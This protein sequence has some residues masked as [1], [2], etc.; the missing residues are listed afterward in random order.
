[1]TPRRSITFVLAALAATTQA[2][3]MQQSEDADVA[4]EVEQF[5]V[6]NA[7]RPGAITAMRVVLTS[8]LD[9]PTPVWVQWEVPNAEGDIAEYGRSVVLNPGSREMVWLYAPLSPHTTDQTRW[10]IRVFEERDG[11]RRRELGG[12]PR[13]SPARSGATRIEL[14]T[15]MIAVVGRARMRLEDYA[16]TWNGRPRPPGAHESTRVISGIA[17]QAL[18]DR[19]EGLSAFEAVIWSDALS[20]LLRNDTA[21]ALRQYIRRGGH[22]II[23]L[24]E[25]GV[26]WELGSVADNLLEDLLVGLKPR[27][28][29]GVMLSELMPLLSKSRHPPV[30]DFEMS[31]RVFKDIGGR[32]DAIDNRYEPLVAM[33]DGRVIAVQRLVDFG[34]ITI[35]GIDLTSQR[36]AS[37]RLPQADAFWNRILGRRD[38]TPQANE[39]LTMDE[40]EPRMLT[41]GTA[42]ELTIGDGRLLDG[43]NKTGR[44][45][46]SLLAAVLLFIVY[47]VVAGPGGFFFLKRQRMAQH[48][49][50]VFAATAGVF[51]AVA[52]GGVRFLRQSDTEF[53]HVTFLDHVVRPATSL[54]SAPHYQRAVSWGSLYLPK[55]G[56]VDVSIE[57]DP[58]ESGQNLLFTWE[59]PPPTQPD[60]FPN[61]D[62]YMIDV[63]RSPADYTLPVRAT[64]TQLYMNW[65]GA[66]DPDWGGTLRVDPDD[67]IRITRGP[68]NFARFS[69][70]LINDLP[71]VLTDV[72][73][74]WVS[75]G[76]N[77]QR[78]YLLDD[79][80]ELS[81][82][83]P[84]RSGQMLNTGHMLAHNASDPW[85]AGTKLSLA[86]FVPDGQT[87][88]ERNIDK[89]YI[90][91]EEGDGMNFTGIGG[92]NWEKR[93]LHNY[94]EMLSLYHQLTPPRY[95]REDDKDPKAAV[96]TR[97]MTRELDL[98]AWFTRPCLI[99]IGYLDASEIPIPLLVD[100]ET[101]RSEGLTVVRWIYP[102]PLVETRIVADPGFTP[103]R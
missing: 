57:D 101:P 8:S 48:S 66:L 77:R 35:I 22:L 88:L 98:S 56:S 1:M 46:R 53:R 67:P 47:F 95:I 5:G 74:I 33:G 93:N 45:A 80:E 54:G 39:L 19:W 41:R 38:D 25:T 83:P 97:R 13:I 34:R 24:P 28:D 31:V 17:P 32:F 64:A 2:G 14:D 12:D 81:W 85:Y 49:W 65:M 15:G 16:T 87:D 20:Q 102:L 71:G 73:V 6:G 91:P 68:G 84:S 61:V 44:A 23:I 103:T 59:A 96:I 94:M 60:R 63:G 92:S 70:T 43:V 62:R 86:E 36:L 11:L 89:K 69:G 100:G 76:R 9:E 30:R 55:Y 18:P 26:S 50:L 10:T 40:S 79:G 52:W 72:C 75:N 4:I 82:V 7:Y 42:N 78:E 99:I 58:G 29:E 27:K 37:M 51:T 3:A 21:N 90:E